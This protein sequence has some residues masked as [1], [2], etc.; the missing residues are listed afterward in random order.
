MTNQEKANEITRRRIQIVADYCAQKGWP[1]PLSPGDLTVEQML[2]IRS[3]PEW[4]GVPELVEK[5]K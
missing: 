1:K 5:I 2:E 3:L 4:K